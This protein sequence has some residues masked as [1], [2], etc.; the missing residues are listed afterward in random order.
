MGLILNRE[1]PKLLKGYPT[2]SDKYD[3]AGGT[4]KA[5]SEKIEVGTVL[6]YTD[7]AGVYAAAT[8]SDAAKVAGVACAPNVKLTDSWEGDGKTYV[9]AGEAVNILVRGFVAVEVDKL[10]G[11]TPNAAVNLSAAGA[12]TAGEGTAISNWVFT[13]ETYDRVLDKSADTHQYLAEV[14]IKK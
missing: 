10:D 11:I 8:A 7:V 12:L 5:G 2:V 14:E 1:L 9:H 13:G 4:L 3:V 6:A